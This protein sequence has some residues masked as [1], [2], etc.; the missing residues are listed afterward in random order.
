MAESVVGS[1]TDLV[2]EYCYR[3]YVQR[4]YGTAWA[5]LSPPHEN[6]WEDV[7]HDAFM[8]FYE[9]AQEGHVDFLQKRNGCPYQQEIHT[10]APA[11]LAW[12]ISTVRNKCQ[13][14]NS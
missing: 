3:R 13:S 4:L 2:V 5:F 7:V 11:C 9:A 10:L 6:L 14:S 12:L 8:A 1:T